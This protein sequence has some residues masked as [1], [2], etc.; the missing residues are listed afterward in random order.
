M[1]KGRVVSFNPRRERLRLAPTSGTNRETLEMLA[2]RLESNDLTAS[3][4]RILLE[5]LGRL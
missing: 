3:Q 1:V 5:I 2:R 4:W